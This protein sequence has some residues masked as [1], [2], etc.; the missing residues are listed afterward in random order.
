MKKM[1]CLLTCVVFVFALS[2]CSG[3]INGD[4]AKVY[5]NDFLAEVEKGDYAAAKAYLHPDRPAN[6][7]AFFEGVATEGDVDFSKISVEKYTNVSS[8]IYDSS[9]GGAK[10]ALTM[11]VDASGKTIEM[12]IEIV[13]ND[14]GYGIYNLDIDPQ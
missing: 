10:Y 1:L 6:L 8:A 2:A 14:N 9:V 4:E 12:E 5:I 3:G 7:Q 11:E 13:R